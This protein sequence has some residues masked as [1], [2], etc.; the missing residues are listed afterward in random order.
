MAPLCVFLACGESS[1]VN[2]E[3]LGATGGEP[4]A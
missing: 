4:L 2:G 1:Y 3:V